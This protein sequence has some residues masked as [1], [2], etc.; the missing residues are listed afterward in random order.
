[1]IYYLVAIYTGTVFLGAYSYLADVIILHFSFQH[2]DHLFT[3]L[4]YFILYK[5]WLLGLI[6]PCY[7]LIFYK[8]NGMERVLYKLSFIIVLSA[9][10]SSVFIK[11]DLCFIGQYKTIRLFSIY[12]FTGISLLW[13]HIKY[14]HQNTKK[15]V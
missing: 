5:A 3:Y 12:F 7:A 2:L 4:V 15:T 14:W 1:V 13:I 8:Y 10:L 6:L 9:C 11:R